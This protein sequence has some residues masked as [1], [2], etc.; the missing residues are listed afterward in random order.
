MQIRKVGVLGTGLMAP[1]IARLSA[2]A[3][4]ETVIRGRTE[5]SV[6]SAVESIRAGLARNVERGKLT[7]QQKDEI[8][9]RLTGATVL[10]ELGGCD[11]VVEA[12]IEELEV[13]RELLAALDKICPPHTIFAS[14]TSSLPIVQLGAATKRPDRVVGMHFLYPPQAMPLL[15]VVRSITSSEESVQTAKSFGQSLG[16]TVVVA[17]DTPGFLFNRMLVPYMMNAIRLLDAGVASAEDI[18]TTMRLGLSCPWGPLEMLD[19]VGIDLTYRS[20]SHFYEEF[21]EPQYAPPPLMK[22][23][24]LAGHWGRKTGKGFYDYPEAGARPERK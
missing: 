13:K 1:G 10:E 16:K 21:K 8:L 12:V 17:K 22:R 19:F 23:M 4:Y 15:E 11:I 2:Q 20:G 5:Q 9:G 3:G 14:N 6:G 7:E 24:I 18:D